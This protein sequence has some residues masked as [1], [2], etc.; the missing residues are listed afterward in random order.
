[1]MIHSFLRIRIPPK[2]K[3]Q[4]LEILKPFVERIKVSPGCLDSHLY[5]DLQEEDV[6]MLEQR[7]RSEQDL[8]C[9]LRSR[10]YRNVLLLMEMAI[11]QPEVRFESIT[12]TSGLEAVAAAR[13]CAEDTS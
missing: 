3:G 11:S 5:K 8:N 7:W 12:H 4:A 10:E 1:M 2:K 9:H 13:G 6:F